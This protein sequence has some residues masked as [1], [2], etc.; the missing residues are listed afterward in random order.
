MVRHGFYL[1]KTADNGYQCHDLNNC[2]ADWL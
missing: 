1:N 2:N